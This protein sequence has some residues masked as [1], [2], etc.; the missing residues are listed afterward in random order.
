MNIETIR[1]PWSLSWTTEKNIPVPS[2]PLT[3][4]STE[5]QFALSL[6]AYSS[7]FVWYLL[8]IE[9]HSRE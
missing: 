9:M 2:T 6:E 3:A 4:V 5:L 8:L 1:M 7:A